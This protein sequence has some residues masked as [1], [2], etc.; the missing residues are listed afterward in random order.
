MTAGL[1]DELRTIAVRLR[2]CAA[3]GEEPAI[4]RPLAALQDVAEKIGK[5]WSGSNLGYQSRVY[6]AG[7]DVPPAGAHFDSEW[8]FR[9]RF[10]GTTGAWQEYQ[11]DQV[12]DHIHD[13][14]QSHEIPDATTAAEVTRKL[15]RSARPEVVSVFSAFLSSSEDALV[16]QL[17]KEAEEVTDLSV[18]DAEGALV[19]PPRTTITRDRTALSQGFMA[20][21]HQQ[22]LARVVSLRSAFAACASLAAI[23]ERGA[24]HLER[25]EASQR[26]KGQQPVAAG[27][28]VFIGHGRSLLWRE[29]KDFVSDDLGLSWDE[30]NRVPVAGLTTTA[31]LSEMLD[32][33][34][35]AFIVLTAEDETKDG[36]ER[37]RQNVVHEAGL[38]QGRLTFSRAIVLLEDG[39]EAFSN[40]AGLVQIRFP[41]GR[42]SA[43]FHEVRRVLEREGFVE[44]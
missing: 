20:A 11:A 23:A 31:R 1:A 38:F 29:L 9:G 43:A 33:A 44:P 42:I 3:Q 19:G 13:L 40:I 41:R 15:W 22:V 8:G 37:A 18:H 14:A 17:L 28:R 5:S 30:F 21:P 26:S 36:T 24:S 4:A 2:E 16:R 32:N 34:G 35:I 25:L 7:F 39:C 12:I 10:Q 6:Y 27:D